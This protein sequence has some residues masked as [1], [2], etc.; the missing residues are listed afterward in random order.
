MSM[1]LMVDA[2]KL[3]IGNPTRKLVLIK[4]ADNANDNGICWPSY[5]HIAEQCEI[6]RR[7]AIR[8]VKELVDMGLIKVTY[9]EGEKGN[10]VTSH[11]E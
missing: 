1:S 5:D 6:S 7:T 4:L 10:W 11:T 9:R 8:Q 2:M 3:K